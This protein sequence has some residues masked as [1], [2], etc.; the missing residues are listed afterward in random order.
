MQTRAER[1]RAAS[2][3]HARHHARLPPP[4][5][6]ARSALQ[7]YIIRQNILVQGLLK[8]INGAAAAAAA[9]GIGRGLQAA[10]NIE[11]SACL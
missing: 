6:P 7:A 3:L 11:E 2:A 8:S 4:A 5:A 1:A 10:F 9:Y